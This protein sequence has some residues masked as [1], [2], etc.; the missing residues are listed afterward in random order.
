[1]ECRDCHETKPLEAFALR[2]RAAGTRMNSCKDCRAAYYRGWKKRTGYD[3]RKAVYDREYRLRPER[4]QGNALRK[5]IA[6]DGRLNPEERRAKKLV[7][8]LFRVKAWNA[9]HPMGDKAHFARQK[10]RKLG[11]EGTLTH[12]QIQARWDFYGG[13]CYLCG[14]EATEI[15]H[16]IPLGRGGPNFASNIRPACQHCNSSKKETPLTEYLAS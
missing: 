7:D 11:V 14:A 9:A 4:V 8:N 1:M 16:V 6:R 5:A 12:T 3:Q 13:R 15:D 2:D 10:A